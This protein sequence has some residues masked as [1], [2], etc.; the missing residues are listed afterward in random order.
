M[1]YN[2]IFK[3]FIFRCPAGQM[4]TGI[5]CVDDN[6]CIGDKNPCQNGGT[7]YN[8]DPGYTCVCPKGYKG[9]N[10]QVLPPDTIVTPPL[11]FAWEGYLIIILCLLLILSKY[12]ILGWFESYEF[13]IYLFCHLIIFSLFKLPPCLHNM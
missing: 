4:A 6:E 8:K 13:V 2:F 10:C 3:S 11:V 1:N 9:E 7:C 12:F 5:Q